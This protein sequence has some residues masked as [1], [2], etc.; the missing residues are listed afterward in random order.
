LVLGTVAALAAVQGCSRDSR[1]IG[2][3]D[4]RLGSQL[5]VAAA[6]APAAEAAPR[7]PIA[8]GQASTPARP[9]LFP[10]RI[11]PDKKYLVNSR[12]E[13]FLIVGNAAWSLAVEA[14]KSEA[15]FYLDDRRRRGFNT[16]VVYLT[17]P[18]FSSH[19]PRWA[20]AEGAV[21]FANPDDF[22]ATN[23]GYF[24]HVDWLVHEA[25]SRGILVILTPSY[26]GYACGDQ[27]WCERMKHN[28]VSRLRQYGQWLGHRYRDFPNIAWLE[29]GDYTPS[30]KGSP[31][32]MDLVTAIAEGVKAGDGGVHL[33]TVEW[34][35]E[36]S[37]SEVPGATWLD[38]DSTY[39]YTAPH[40]YTK[41]LADFARDDRVGPFFNFEPLYENEHHTSQLQL[42]S[43]MYQ[44]IL[45][46]A[47][48]FMFGMFPVWNFWSPGKPSWQF[49][50]HGYPA[51]WR[52]A[53][54]SPGTQGVTR[55]AEFFRTRAWYGLR[56][57]VSHAIMTAGY[58]TYG[59]DQFALLASTSDG[60]LAIAYYTAPLSATV[61]M[62]RMSGSTLVRW[63]DPSSGKYVDVPGSPFPNSGTRVFTPSREN[64][65]GESD[66]VLVLEVR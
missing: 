26:I 46:G 15:L 38:L 28:G 64:A 37:G 35:T 19:I 56:P 52:S 29:S 49:D 36:T 66:W 2:A 10:L 50:D 14:T 51:G 61:N 23:E 27:G 20:N 41:T 63:F 9:A 4:T 40:L 53:L 57:D 25:D 8:L 16:I 48:G 18:R 11:S 13:P 39:S 31:S 5:T 1:W 6:T 42:R 34:S 59:S 17:T 30:R 47:T 65:E 3:C 32:E 43:Q 24:A 44:P 54:D 12:N 62:A 58:G 7:D 21:P 45:S 55:T 22:T 60:R 33:H